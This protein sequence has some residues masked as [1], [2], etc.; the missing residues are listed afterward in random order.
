M[1]NFSDPYDWDGVC[2]ER[3]VDVHGTAAIGF[4][5]RRQSSIDIRTV[6][7]PWSLLVPF[8]HPVPLALASRPL[9]HH[10]RCQL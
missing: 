4:A 1:N 6:A 7:L 10:L 3:K 8:L 5:E 9:R 2:D